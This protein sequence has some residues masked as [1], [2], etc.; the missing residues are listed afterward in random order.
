[1]L[2]LQSFLFLVALSM[3]WTWLLQLSSTS[4]AAKQLGNRPHQMD[5]KVLLQLMAIGLRQY[6]YSSFD[7]L[8]IT[9]CQVE[10]LWQLHGLPSKLILGCYLLNDQFEHLW[11]RRNRHTHELMIQGYS[12]TELREFCWE[13]LPPIQFHF[14]CRLALDE[15]H[16]LEGYLHSKWNTAEF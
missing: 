12:S 16:A 6:W 3:P 8:P 11:Y 1:M 7:L 13:R 2:S 4:L 15:S 14:I 5:S 10:V 9:G